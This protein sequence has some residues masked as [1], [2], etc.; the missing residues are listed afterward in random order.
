MQRPIISVDQYP[1][2]TEAMH[3]AGQGNWH[4]FRALGF[5]ASTVLDAAVEWKRHIDG[6][7][8]PWLCWNIH[9]DWCIVQQRLVESVGWTPIVGYDPRVGPPKKISKRSILIDFNAA[10]RLPV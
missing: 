7:K 5:D 4:A 9:E 2:E 1:S 3:R 8:L 10:L 6:V